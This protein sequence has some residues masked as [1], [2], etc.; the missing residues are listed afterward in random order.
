VYSHI[1]G[2]FPPE[3]AAAAQE[4]LR[5]W[6]WE[7]F[8]TAKER[9][10]KLSPQSYTRMAGLFEHKLETIAPELLAEIE[11][12]KAQFPLVSPSSCLE[13]VEVPIYLLHGAADNVIPATETLW[14][15][16]HAPSRWLAQ[17][18]VSKAISHVELQGKPGWS[19]QFLLVHFMAGLLDEMD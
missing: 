12:R 15:A 1:E 7:E 9:A 2:F 16:H 4:A 18:L 3:E 19:D 6:L 5:Y 8:D 10:K 17:A 13:R 11:R 14:L